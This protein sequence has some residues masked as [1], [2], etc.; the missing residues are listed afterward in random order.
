M[1]TIC[2]T[3]LSIVAWL[4]L[5]F[6]QPVIVVRGET[7]RIAL[8]PVSAHTCLDVDFIH[9]VQRTRV[10]EHLIA[11]PRL[12]GFIL[13]ETEYASFGFGLPFLASDGSFSITEHG[14]SLK[15]MNRPISS[16]SLRPGVKTELTI[17]IDGIPYP[18]YQLVPLGSRVDIS[19][20][21]GYEIFFIR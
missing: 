9:S 14:F 20:V 2:M 13:Q 10:T 12:N 17:Y 11:N 15:D 3:L 16:L 7:G 4:G 1:K 6:Y 5:L 8:R 21:K 19:I 18:L